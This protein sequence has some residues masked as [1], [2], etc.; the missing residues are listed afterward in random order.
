MSLKT[1][2][3]DLKNAMHMSD[4]CVIWRMR[5]SLECF[6]LLSW[7]VTLDVTSRC[8]ITS[9]LYDT[10]SSG[11]ATRLDIFCGIPLT[12]VALAQSKEWPRECTSFCYG[13]PITKSHFPNQIKWMFHFQIIITIIKFLNK[14]HLAST[15]IILIKLMLRTFATGL[16]L[17]IR[18][19]WI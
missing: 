17:S 2:S 12:L 9:T 14:F 3:K 19:I 16:K 4:C 15:L 6:G 13:Q 11:Q 10:Q 18:G 8:Q 1:L 5:E 7:T